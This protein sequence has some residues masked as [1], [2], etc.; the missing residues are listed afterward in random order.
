[1]VVGWLGEVSLLVVV[2]AGYRPD[3]SDQDCGNSPDEQGSRDCTQNNQ[4]VVRK[5]LVHDSMIHAAGSSSRCCSMAP[6]T[7]LRASCGISRNRYRHVESSQILSSY[8]DVPVS[9]KN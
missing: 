3:I 2:K 9:N 8:F 7:C 4:Q 1:M 5:H 6:S